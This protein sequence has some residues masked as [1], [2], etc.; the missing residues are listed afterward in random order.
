MKKNFSINIIPIQNELAWEF[1]EASYLVW[2]SPRTMTGS[3]KHVSSSPVEQ[4]CYLNHGHKH[5]ASACT[6]WQVNYWPRAAFEGQD[7]VNFLR[8]SQRPSYRN[9]PWITGLKA[10]AWK[11]VTCHNLCPETEQRRGKIPTEQEG[12]KIHLVHTILQMEKLSLWS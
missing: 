9:I 8:K 11:K 2:T 4:L 5:L 10:E 3:L 7:H 12:K 1:K 6:K